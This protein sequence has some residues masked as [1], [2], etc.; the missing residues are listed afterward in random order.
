MD[1]ITST[2]HF[3]GAFSDTEARLLRTVGQAGNWLPEPRCLRMI[4]QEALEF[5]RYVGYIEKASFGGYKIRGS[6]Q[7]VKRT[8]A[9]TAHAVRDLLAAAGVDTARIKYIG[10][11]DGAWKRDGGQQWTVIMRDSLGLCG[12]NMAAFENVIVDGRKI[13]VRVKE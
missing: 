6:V 13:V 11:A 1:Y 12:A 9:P 4:E 7:V 8:P 5:L 10:V 3:P 2:R